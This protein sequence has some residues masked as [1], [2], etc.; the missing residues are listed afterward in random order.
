MEV[1]GDRRGERTVNENSRK[2]LANGKIG[3][4]RGDAFWSGG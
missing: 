4:E 2:G 3:R 1:R